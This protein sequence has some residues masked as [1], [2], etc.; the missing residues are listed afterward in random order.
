MHMGGDRRLEKDEIAA[1]RLGIELGLTHIDTAEMY[2]DGHAEEIVAAAVAKQRDRVFIGTKVMPSNASYKGTLAACERSLKRLR[3]DYVDLYML[4]WWS[5]AHPLEDTMR[6]MVKLCASG[7]TRFAGVSNCEV[8][9]MQLAE[10]ALG[11]VPLACNQV[12]HGLDD[13]GIELDVIPYCKRHRIAVVGYSPLSRGGFTRGAVVDVARRLGKTPALVAL[14]FLT[15]RP[16]VFAIAKATRREHVV[17]NAGALDFTL[18]REDVL[19]I[20]G[21][22]RR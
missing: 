7:K 21:A 17:E 9:Q 19:A 22:D 10:A 16:W 1:L 14:N 18:S 20:D 8:E 4:H 12:L 11:K 2:A 13:R 3:T 5:G 6:A 15:R